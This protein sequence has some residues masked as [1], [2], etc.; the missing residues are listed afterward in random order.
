[1]DLV[2]RQECDPVAARL[3]MFLAADRPALLQDGAEAPLRL[4]AELLHEIHQVRTEHE[5]VF[6]PAAGVFLAAGPELQHLADLAGAVQLGDDRQPRA[7]AGLKRDG[8]RILCFWQ[9]AIIAS[10]SAKVRANGLSI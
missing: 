4:A 3:E 5:E 7:V 2:T 1:M 9:A 6:G 10:A 8:R